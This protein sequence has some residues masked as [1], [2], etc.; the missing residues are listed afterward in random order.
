MSDQQAWHAGT[1]RL[2]EVLA[3]LKDEAGKHLRPLL[4]QYQESKNAIIDITAGIDSARICAE[5]A[6]KCCANGKYRF[7]VL[8]RLVCLVEDVAVV[9]DFAQKP[10]CPYAASDGCR[11]G[12]TL[13][14]LDCVL[15]ICDDIERRVPQHVRLQ[16]EE[17]ELQA[18][19][20]LRAATRLLGLPL[21]TPLLLW[22][23]QFAGH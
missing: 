3:G 1:R 5:C 9:T 10:L 19:S 6:G 15:F 11:L 23:E 2:G 13:R 17:L 21:A 7:N 4:L 14:P 20:A 8:D 12:A 18:R 16:L 22:A